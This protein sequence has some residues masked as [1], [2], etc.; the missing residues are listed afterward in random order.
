[1]AKVRIVYV[2]DG[3]EPQR[4][5]LRNYRKFLHMVAQGLATKLAD[6]VEESNSEDVVNVEGLT[7]STAQRLYFG[8]F[9]EKETEED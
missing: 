8:T 5:T 1:M 3:G 6:H 4:L 9:A 2:S 7:K